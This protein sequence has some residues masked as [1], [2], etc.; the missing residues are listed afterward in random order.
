MEDRLN[1]NSD[2]TF[3]LEGGVDGSLPYLPV[4]AS[5]LQGIWWKV[6]LRYACKPHIPLCYCLE[7]IIPRFRPAGFV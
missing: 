4:V 6:V 7:H 2:S 5:C 3:K 1:V